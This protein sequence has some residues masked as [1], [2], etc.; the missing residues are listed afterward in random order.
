MSRSQALE[1]FEGVTFKRHNSR[2]GFNIN[3][4]RR[5]SIWVN[6]NAGTG[7]YYDGEPPYV[8]R[9]REG[10]I[11]FT[12]RPNSRFETSL[13]N[14]ISRMADLNTEEEI[15]DVRLYR[16]RTTYQFSDRFLLR[17]IV[18]YNSYY[19]KLGVNLMLTYRVNAGTVVFVG[20]DDRMRRGIDIN[21]ELYSDNQMRRTNQMFFAKISYLFRP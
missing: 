12:L 11:S 20:Y 9:S 18:E 3:T 21:D 13:T 16:L 2:V 15:Y 7:I 17:N 19:G 1:R 6:W 10:F 5:F 14:N 4:S 8:G